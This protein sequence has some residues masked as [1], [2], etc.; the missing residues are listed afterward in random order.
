MTGGEDKVTGQE[1]ARADRLTGPADRIAVGRLSHN[2]RNAVVVEPAHLTFC[3]SA[4]T[5]DR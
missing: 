4:W 3:G 1:V 5:A 2:Q